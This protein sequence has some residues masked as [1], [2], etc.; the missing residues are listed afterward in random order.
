MRD[1]KIGDFRRIITFLERKPRL[2][3]ELDRWGTRYYPEQR[4]HTIAMC[5][6]QEVK[7]RPNYS[8]WVMW[9]NLKNPGILLW[10]ADVLGEDEDRIRQACQEAA[11]AHTGIKKRDCILESNAFRRVIPWA[12]IMELL[13]HPEKWR[14]EKDLS[15][16][17]SLNGRGIPRMKGVLTK[18]VYEKTG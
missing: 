4:S 9:G 13:D 5:D 15:K 12:R 16:R 3:T 7:E 2:T 18:E 6:W 10:V 1:I 11:W 8:T 14:R 17:G